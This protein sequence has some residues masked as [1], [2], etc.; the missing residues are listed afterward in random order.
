MR[1]GAA[2]ALSAPY[3]VL[4]CCPAR[5]LNPMGKVKYMPA[6]KLNAETESIN[7]LWE[8]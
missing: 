8:R 6:Q 3:A 4:F 7:S 5:G 1:K 2:D